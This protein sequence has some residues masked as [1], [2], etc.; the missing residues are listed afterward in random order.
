GQLL[1]LVLVAHQLVANLNAWWTYIIAFFL[2]RIF[3]I[4]KPQPAKWADTKVENAHG[5]MLDDVFAGL[6]AAII[7]LIISNYLEIL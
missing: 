6:Y 1:S 3:D 2:F 4:W 5:V 7:L